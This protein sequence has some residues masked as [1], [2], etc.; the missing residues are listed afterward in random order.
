MVLVYLPMG[1]Y[2]DLFMYRRRQRKKALE[3]QKGNEKK[4]S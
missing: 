3:K 1:Y 2:T 4:A